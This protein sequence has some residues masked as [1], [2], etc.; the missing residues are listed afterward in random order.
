MHH[1]TR[2]RLILIA[3][4]LIAGFAAGCTPQARKARHLAQAD[5]Y[6]DTGDYSKAEGEYLNVLKVDRL[7]PHAIGQLGTIYYDQG[8]IQRAYPFI[9][10]ARELDPTNS[11]LRV[12]AGYLR[13]IE[14]KSK[15]ARAEAE[16]ILE[17][18][19]RS[20]DAPL[21]LASTVRTLAEAAE[22]RQRLENLAKLDGDSA[23]LSVALGT[24]SLRGGDVKAAETSFKHATELDPKSAQ[25]HYSLGVLNWAQ[26]N[27]TN[28]DNELKTAAELSPVRSPRR[29][30]YA[31][32]KL[33]Q[34]R[35]DDA[36]HLLSRMTTECPDSLPAWNALAQIALAQKQYDECESYIKQALARDQANFDTLMLSCNLRLS[37]G[38][39]DRAITELERMTALFDKSPQPRY[40]LALAYLSK[41]DANK[42]AKSINEA[43]ALNPNYDD[44]ILLQAQLNLRRDNAGAAIL[45]LTQ[46]INRRPQLVPAYLL[47]GSACAAKGNFDDALTTYQRLAQIN[48][49]NSQ[50][51]LLIGNIYMRQ[52]KM[53]DARKAF[54][55]SLELAPGNLPALEQLVG[56]DLTETNYAA[57]LGRIQSEVA[58]RPESPELHVLLAQIFIARMG[59]ARKAIQYSL[60]PAPGN[61]QAL[62]QLVSLDLIQ[63]NYDAALSRVQSEVTK[64][65]ESPALQV[66]LT[67]M[68][69]AKKDQEQAEMALQQAITLSP[70]YQLAYL[71]LAELYRDSNRNDEA[72]KRLNQV[73]ARN[74]KDQSALMFTGMIQNEQQKYAAA[75][76]TYEQLLAINPNFSPALNNLAYLYSEKFDMLPKAYEA[77]R[78]AR[79]LLPNDP[80]TADTLG[81][82]LYKRGE[83][84]WALS[85]LQESAERIPKNAEVQFHLGMAYYMVNDE[86]RAQKALG[87]AIVSPQDFA[88]KD[89]ATNRLALLA[90]DPKT[91]GPEAIAALEK[92]VS[93]KSDDPI[94][95]SRLA[96]I[97]D[98]QGALEKAVKVY[99]QA[100]QQNPKNAQLL[101]DLAQLYA[102]R[103]QNP[104]KAMALAKDAYK[105][106]PDDAD[107][108]YALGR[109][110]LA[111]GD[112]KWALSLL[113]RAEQKQTPQPEQQFDLAIAYYSVGRLA[114]AESKMRDALRADESFAHAAEAKQF[115]ELIALPASPTKAVDALPRI[116]QILQADPANV[117]ALMVLAA[118]SE[119]QNDA[120]AAG[121]AC[122][123]ALK[124]YPD[125]VPAIKRLAILNA[126]KL[127][128][129]KKAYDL[130]LKAR[131]ALPEDTEIARTL[132]ILMFR[133]GDFRGAVRLL[134]ET[135]QKETADGATWYYL[136]MSQYRLKQTKESKDALT[137]ALAM[138]VPTPLAEEARRV[139]K[140]LK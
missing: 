109:M 100:L 87:R 116:K 81:W 61:L 58:K 73:L 37:K 129:D 56:L 22:S 75:R 2:T 53:D 59:D 32:F 5:K 63:T 31:D 132:G 49:T 18:D 82:V 106:A 130:A 135:S 70:N 97:Y 19:P 86:A 33:K 98:R 51:P 64:H 134:T 14:G 88:G 24:L 41:G 72:L 12:K 140:E 107:I 57:A 99:E 112:G 65:P 6:F 38:E 47:L 117:P 50:V 137:R 21:L 105:L 115:L 83:Y 45:S 42:S 11:A 26:G 54:E 48:P 108:S 46:L 136:G 17:S 120:R 85:L 10:K 43:V 96:A 123:Q 90:L 93:E 110:A 121:T 91:A 44:A 124:R 13:L 15:E 122:E 9:M 131:E 25:A 133:R 111:G 20:V 102:Y 119:Q 94:A 128:D 52:T 8:R 62:E 126:D 71:T 139:L 103:L 28:A 60:E 125:F 113:Q 1:L 27:L 78:K 34:G 7:N 95:L 127:G 39:I 104:A 69:T 55:H 66:L 16:G 79:E 76:S 114:D 29:I 101:L 4:A 89:E 77:A 30:D 118:A 92:R 80:F 3:I 23:P 35:V 74:P 84:T 68:V 67:Q 138:N 40:V 36:K